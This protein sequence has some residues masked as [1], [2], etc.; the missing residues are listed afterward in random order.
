MLN[1]F[2]SSRMLIDIKDEYLT[3]YYHYNKLQC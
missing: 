3:L 2:S 1:M